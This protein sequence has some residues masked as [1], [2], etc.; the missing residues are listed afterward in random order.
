[1]KPLT[2]KQLWALG[3]LAALSPLLRLVPEGN[4]RAA[5]TAGW[6]SPLA[7]LPALLLYASLLR[8]LLAL[9]EGS[10]PL[11]SLLHR[12]C[13]R[14]VIVLCGV[15]F[16]LYA[17]FLLRAG[18][19]RFYA[20]LG[21]FTRWEPFALALLAAAIP[22]A[23]GGQK[24]L[25]RAAQ[26]F[27]AAVSGILLLV[28]VC[29]APQMHWDQLRAV[30]IGNTQNILRGAVP[31]ANVGAAALFL[32]AF[33]APPGKF[34]A[35]RAAGFALR[36]AG[37]A[38]ILSALA[39]GIFGAELTTHLSHPFFVLLRNVRLSR[40]MERMEALISAVW[41]LPDLVMLAALLLV[42]RETLSPRD[43]PLPVWLLGG[44]VGALAAL[45]SPTAF[46]LRLWSETIIPAANA[47][48]V[49]LVPLLGLLCG[50]KN[51]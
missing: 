31:T 39:A 20:A 33:L 47:L 28:I 3:S 8:R 10:E 25:G 7:A 30:W 51:D 1:M 24:A 13:G 48:V 19:E 42:G 17:A 41:V 50:R 11:S 34:D 22:A 38:A 46:D 15:W 16:L 2:K 4:L 45:L 35:R 14:A 5:G 6:L 27:L 9:R 36:L 21:V 43:K 40:A 37:T 23:A 32:L 26:I 29:A 18:A 49:L 12:S 44:I